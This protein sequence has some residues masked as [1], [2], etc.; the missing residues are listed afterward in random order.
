MEM[1]FTKLDLGIIKMIHLVKMFGTTVKNMLVISTIT[2]GFAVL[3]GILIV[4]TLVL[5]MV[6]SLKH[7]R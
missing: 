2:N 4:L 6:S 1:L 5:Y 3:A 7:T